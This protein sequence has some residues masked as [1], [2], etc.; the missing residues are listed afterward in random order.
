M[1]VASAKAGAHRD[2]L[3]VAPN[4]LV[5]RGRFTTAD[6]GRTDTQL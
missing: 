1:P 2:R 6:L 3:V 5:S 4:V